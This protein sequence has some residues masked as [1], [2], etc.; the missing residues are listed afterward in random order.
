MR[1]TLVDSIVR[2]DF[3]WTF[4]TA[5]NRDWVLRVYFI[6]VVA[7]IPVSFLLPETHGPTILAKRAKR[8]QSLENGRAG[9]GLYLG[10]GEDAIP[11]KNVSNIVRTHILRPACEWDQ[12]SSWK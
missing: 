9:A 4:D 1:N 10:L 5:F 11:Q 12:H 8:V 2:R 7:L 6:V 3:L